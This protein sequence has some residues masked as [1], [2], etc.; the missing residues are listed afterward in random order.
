MVSRAISWT[1]LLTEKKK[2]PSI[3]T[4]VV[5]SFSVT[6]AKNL[7][8]LIALMQRK[9]SLF[10]RPVKEKRFPTEQRR[11]WRSIIRG[12]LLS[13][14]RH[15]SQ[16]NLWARGGIQVKYKFLFVLLFP[17]V[18]K[19]FRGAKTR[20]KLYSTGCQF[21]SRSNSCSPKNLFLFGRQQ[22]SIIM[23]KVIK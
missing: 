21:S 22:R 10:A 13:N 4:E 14:P 5:S 8:K 11:V 6:I 3:L 7:S 9:W 18:P 17:K 2:S 16:A 1:S 15:S 12:Y 23:N 19:E 20:Y